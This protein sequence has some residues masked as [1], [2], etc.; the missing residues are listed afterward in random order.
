MPPYA[1]RNR[2]EVAITAAV[3]ITFVAVPVSIFPVGARIALTTGI[4]LAV[5]AVPVLLVLAASRRW[6]EY[7]SDLSDVAAVA[8]LAFP[9][10]WG[11]VWILAGF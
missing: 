5:L 10:L 8:L 1:D 7:P 4:T 6:S 3:V 9:F 11:L 2:R